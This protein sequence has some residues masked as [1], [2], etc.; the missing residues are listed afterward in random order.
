M[1]RCTLVDEIG[2]MPQVKTVAGVT[3]VSTTV[4][5]VTICIVVTVV[6]FVEK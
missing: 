4:N 1:R 2:A 3:C 6:M 5:I